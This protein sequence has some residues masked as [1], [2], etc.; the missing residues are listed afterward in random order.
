MFEL[1]EQA[2]IVTLKMAHE[3]VNAM[4]LEFLLALNGHL[5]ELA[6]DD[7][8]RG[9]IIVGNERVFSAGVDLKRL[10]GEGPGYLDQFL[11][12]LTLMFQN[13]F[14]FPRPVVAAVGG[15]AIAGGCVMACAA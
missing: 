4:N 11:P 9:L 13:L 8:V 6:A 7:G 10:I 3:Q 14:V 12:E 5:R 15:A 1:A 2:G